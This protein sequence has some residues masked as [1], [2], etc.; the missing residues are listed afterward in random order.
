MA[1]NKKN[2]IPPDPSKIKISQPLLIKLQKEESR[3]QQRAQKFKMNK[4]IKRKIRALLAAAT[5]AIGG[6]QTVDAILSNPTTKFEKNFTIAVANP[7]A[8]ITVD[9]EKYAIDSNSFVIVSGN[10]ALAY[11]DNGNI[12][13]GHV[14]NEDIKEVLTI[15]EEKMSNYNIY[16]IIVEEGA[17][18][19]S[20]GRIEEN[21]I[22]STVGY[23][24][25]V[26]GYTP[27]TDEYDGEWISTLS[28]CGND[29]YD[30]YIR[31]DLIQEI[32]SFDTIYDRAN[33]N[34]EN[35]MI[36]DTSKDGNINLNLRTQPG[37]LDKR[38]I[39]T[40]IPNGSIVH[41]IGE[42]VSLENRD[43]TQIEYK[44][45]SDYKI[46]GWVAADY[47]TPY[48]VSQTPIEKQEIVKNIE[49]IK[50]NAT[51]NVT[52]IDVSAISPNDLRELL[53]TG[54][55]EKVSSTYGSIDTSQFSG[56]INFVYIKLGASSYGNGEFSPLDYT[57][58]EEQVK[59]CEELGVPYG[60]YYYS[61]SKTVE[62]AKIELEHIKQK[63]E[64]LRQKID[65]KNNKLEIV[66]DVELSGT[67]DRQY[68]GNIAEQTEAKATLI[69]GIQKEGLSNYVLIYG[70][71]RVMKPDSDQI[72][73]LS[74][75]RPMLSNPDNV[76]LWLCAPTNINGQLPSNIEKDQA[77]AREQGFSTVAFQVVLD[78]N[79]I[80]K[81]D[82][83]NMSLEHFDEILNRSLPKKELGEDR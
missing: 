4:K 78:G 43:W 20:A 36:V 45:S 1:K 74:Y 51:G 52:G 48:Y 18:V 81:I 23:Q 35:M 53:K 79:V 34:S 57:L 37:D 14:R 24:D 21:N 26:L 39:M 70:P 73:S 25:Y 2:I 46:Q 56:N 42:T 69:N 41:V 22:I 65:M 60:F 17:N 7:D 13:K 64:C 58:Y 11:D 47:L 77:Y 15:D 12:R 61:T 62:E 5:I 63:I 83:N 10:E 33:E 71:S 19:R 75:L 54:I 16:Q 66:V 55:P 31:E 6:F 8:E 29:I 40:T 44:S 67:N 82:I 30:G 28:T 59:V 80:G 50:N 76:A 68:Q 32:G 49:G 27:T 9:R 38:L 72:I 3:S